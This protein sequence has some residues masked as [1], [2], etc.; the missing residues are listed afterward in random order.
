MLSMLK[1]ILPLPEAVAGPTAFKTVSS[2]IAFFKF[3]KC[4]NAFLLADMIRSSELDSTICWSRGRNLPL[5]N[6]KTLIVTKTTTRNVQ[7]K[8]KLN[9][10]HTALIIRFEK[11]CFIWFKYTCIFIIYLLDH[12]N[13]QRA[14]TSL[15][16]ITPFL[17]HTFHSFLG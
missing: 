16:H 4:L 1:I 14:S 3:G 6:L 17:L 8:F 9:K 2:S 12:T 11:A 7:D 5:Y 10:I 13:L 15:V